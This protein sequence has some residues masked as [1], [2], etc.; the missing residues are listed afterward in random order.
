MKSDV[1]DPYLWILE[2][3]RLNREVEKCKNGKRKDTGNHNGM[4]A[5]KR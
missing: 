4:I 5:Q 3:E 1:Y 2:M